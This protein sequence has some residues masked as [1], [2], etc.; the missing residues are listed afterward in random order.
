MELKHNANFREKYLEPA[1]SEGYIEMKY[2]QSRNHP[3]QSYFPTE[4]G[5]FLTEK[6]K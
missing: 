1:L 4:K 6:I 5:K 3:Q 2:P